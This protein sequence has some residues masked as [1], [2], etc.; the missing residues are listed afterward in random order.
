MIK[1]KLASSLGTREETPNIK[2]AQE[3]V[4]SKNVE[5]INKVIELLLMNDKKIQQDCIKVAYEIGRINPQLISDF[6]PIFI[7]LLRSRHNR[8]VWGAMQVLS[9]I[10]IHSHEILI[11]NLHEI[12]LAVKIGSVITVDK[13][14]LTL[15]KLASINNH[16]NEQIFP[17]LIQHLKDCNP[18]QLP[19]HAES[20]LQAVNE[21]NKKEYVQ[22]L[23]A[24]LPYLSP[25]K[26]KRIRKILKQLNE[27]D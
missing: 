3:L 16:Y 4:E 10:A 21:N 1:D 5:G 26:A 11:E 18:K 7:Q 12:K 19:Q 22:I 6:A 13:G 23:K 24:R 9:T 20:V 25:P 15:S 2:L 17:F 8:L 14:I 27:V